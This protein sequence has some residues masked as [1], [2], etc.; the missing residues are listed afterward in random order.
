[1]LKNQLK[2]AWRNLVKNKGFTF[3]NVL[4]LSIGV[5]ACILISIYILHETSYDQRVR[6]SENVYRMIGTYIED[7][8]RAERGVHFSANTA[9]TVLK[10]FPEVELAG[11]IMDNDLFYGAGNNEIR[12]EGESMQH[13]EEGFAYADPSIVNI[14]D[15]QLIH[16]DRSSA[17]SEPRTIVLSQ[18]IAEKYFKTENP[19]GKVMYL[20]GNT[21]DTF[22][23]NGVMADFPSNSH[24]NYD[25]FI[26]LVGVEFGEGE[27]TRWFQNNYYTYIVL[28]PGTDTAAFEKKVSNTLINTYMKPA[29]LA[30]G[31]VSGESLEN[32]LSMSLQ[33]LT[34]INLYSA[35][36][37]F[38]SAYRND[39]K[40]VWVFG[41]IALFILVIASINFV[42]LSTAKSINRAKE[43]GVRKVV[44]SSRKYLIAQF[45]TE[46]VLITILSFAFGVLLSVLLMPFFREISGKM[47]SVPWGSPTFFPLI[48]AS[49]LLVGILAGLYPSFYL[50]R[51]NPVYVLKGK[52]VK[53]KKSVGLRSGLV[54]F[55]FTIS[56]FLIVGTLIVNQQMNFILNSKVGFEKEQ[57][58]Q[59][60]GTNLL[61]DKISTFKE[62]LKKVNGVSHVSISDYLPIEGTKRNGNSFVNEGRD[63][64]DETV[65]GQAWDIDEDYLETLGM[66]LVKGRNFSK[67]RASDDRATIINQAMVKKLQLDE[68]IG[69][70]I[71]RYGRLYEIIGVVKD[72]N[73]NSMKQQVEPLC[74]FYGIS[75]SIVSLKVNTG[76]MPQLLSTI[77]KQWQQFSPTSAF[78]F[79]FM[80]DSYAKMYANVSRVRSIFLSF[81]MLAIF[82]ACLGLFALSAFMVE[83]CKK[84]ISIRMV[85]GASF[86]NIYKLLSF[87]YLKLIA[88]S[89]I[90]ALPIGWYIMNRWLEDFAYKAKMGWEIF[91]GSSILAVIIA[92]VTISYQSISAALAVPVKGLRTE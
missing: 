43:V 23:I 71:S 21:E 81:A 86:Q 31:F 37:D 65:G 69:K 60:Y 78:R 5:A 84:E 63:N 45:L 73:Y 68:P 27:Q 64:L 85:L 16:G 24:L 53:T 56:I 76:D 15:I 6:N 35:D 83:Q 59:L 40:V 4:G 52:M 58:V 32:Q 61:G 57:V 17:L 75:P 80:S 49:A 66:V 12:F 29:Y 92:L 55:Q 87:N 89:T 20:N 44:G 22:R 30:A 2:I 11:R 48:L 9:R 33:P 8:S 13:H 54:V 79:A 91:L 26:S 82:V 18:S 46:S 19:I 90:I 38:E 50:S 51:F 74:F 47:L 72:F 36:I 10:D 25:F 70:K 14:M 7:G 1:M 3:I 67:D 28:K 34:D 77:E 39:I 41:I 62:E 42:N 88:L